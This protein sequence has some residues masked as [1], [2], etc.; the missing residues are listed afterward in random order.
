MAHYSPKQTN[1]KK[2]TVSLKRQTSQDN[3]FSTS[4]CMGICKPGLF[5][6]IPLIFFKTFTLYWNV[7]RVDLQ[8]CVSFSCIAK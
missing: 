2:I 1:L 3:D 5:E 7:S 4:L 8:C 6:I